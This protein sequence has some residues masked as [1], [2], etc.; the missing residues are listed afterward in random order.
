MAW[1]AAPPSPA[2]TASQIL[3]GN[4]TANP[5]SSPCF[6]YQT[7]R[8]RHQRHDDLLRHRRRHH[9]DGADAV[10]DPV[11]K[12]FQTETKALL[13]VSPRNV[14]NAW[15]LAGLGIYEPRP[16]DAAERRRLLLP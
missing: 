10:I 13:N 8:G 2:P 6:T 11:T 14:F 9:A 5:D 12:Q 3:L 16:A 7:Q 1:N 15:Q 4:I